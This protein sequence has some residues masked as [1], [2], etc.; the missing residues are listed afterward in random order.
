MLLAML[1]L[2]QGCNRKEVRESAE[3]SPVS[4][5]KR[6]RAAGSVTTKGAFTE[7]EREEFESKLGELEENRGNFLSVYFSGSPL[8]PLF[9][10]I[11]CAE[12]IEI[13]G[14]HHYEPGSDDERVILMRY[15]D[16]KAKDNPEEC[17]QLLEERNDPKLANLCLAALAEVEPEEA[18]RILEAVIGNGSLR[19][20]ALGNLFN[21][22]AHGDIQRAVKL[23]ESLKT[24]QDRAATAIEVLAS[25]DVSMVPIEVISP[26]ILNNPKAFAGDNAV[27]AVQA[28][29]TH[30]TKEVLRMLDPAVPWQRQLLL[31]YLVDRGRFAKDDVKDYIESSAGQSAFA[32][33]ER[34]TIMASFGSNAPKGHDH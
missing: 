5:T 31:G 6:E 14:S 1:L 4:S 23:V 28:I 27:H 29:R 21:A 22:A 24:P 15:F 20:V 34:R 12:L 3:K 26:L 32:E 30:P 13:L 7:R 33:E 8:D 25:S 9:P 2:L 16:L 19:S 10:R 17:K 18:L 11:S